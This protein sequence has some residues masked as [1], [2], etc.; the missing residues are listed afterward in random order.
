MDLTL[1]GELLPDNMETEVVDW[2]NTYIIHVL[3]TLPNN[4][5][6]A[7]IT[8]KKQKS[9][10]KLKEMALQD[11]CRVCSELTTNAIV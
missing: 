10:G 6:D 2:T 4:F 7:H 11:G 9:P 3:F 5:P 8:F 1:S